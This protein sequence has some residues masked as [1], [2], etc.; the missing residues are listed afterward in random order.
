MMWLWSQAG[1]I[2]L[3]V[4]AGIYHETGRSINDAV[5]VA[6]Q[7]GGSDDNRRMVCVDFITVKT[8]LLLLLGV[9]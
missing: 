9:Y 3:V 1:V 4:S 6:P 5:V 7:M 2:W 8:F